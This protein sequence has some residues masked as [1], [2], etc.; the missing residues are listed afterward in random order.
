MARKMVLPP[1][2]VLG[3]IITTQ[4]I[5]T[6]SDYYDEYDGDVVEVSRRA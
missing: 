2:I 1:A 5:L 4:Y 3:T 6:S